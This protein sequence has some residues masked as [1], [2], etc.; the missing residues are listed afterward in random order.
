M[1]NQ[2]LEGGDPRKELWG[3]RDLTGRGRQAA[4]TM[5]R[6]PQDTEEGNVDLSSGHRQ[7]RHLRARQA[8]TG[9][10]PATEFGGHLDRGHAELTQSQRE[11][12]SRRWEN[13]QVAAG[14]GGVL[15]G[16]DHLCKGKGELF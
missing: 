2:K 1:A 3:L 5:G 7:G 6:G 16:D 13:S 11:V 12:R 10:R 9:S 15:Q 8:W 4:S 14:G